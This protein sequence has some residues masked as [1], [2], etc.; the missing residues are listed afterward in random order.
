MTTPYLRALG[1]CIHDSPELFKA[2]PLPKVY[3]KALIRAAFPQSWR[4]MLAAGLPKKQLNEKQ[5]EL[6]EQLPTENIS[7]NEFVVLLNAVRAETKQT[8]EGLQLAGSNIHARNTSLPYLTKL[9]QDLEPAG[10]KISV[11]ADM[12]SIVL[13]AEHASAQSV[14]LSSKFYTENNTSFPTVAEYILPQRK[15]GQKEERLAELC[16]M[17]DLLKVD[18]SIIPGGNEWAAE[19]NKEVWNCK[20]QAPQRIDRV[21][22]EHQISAQTKQYSKLYGT[23]NMDALSRPLAT[24]FEDLNAEKLVFEEKFRKD[25]LTSM[26]KVE[27]QRLSTS[28]DSE[29]ALLEKHQLSDAEA[30][31]KTRQRASEIA[32]SRVQLVRNSVKA[33]VYAEPG[34]KEALEWANS[35]DFSRDPIDKVRTAVLTMEKH[36]NLLSRFQMQK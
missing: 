2:D 8:P 33:R 12:L 18:F 14:P 28:L 6:L 32:E 5:L 34:G 13:L 3:I 10:S 17:L 21:R 23:T 29:I 16:S 30:L 24:A 36:I 26:K 27:L 9:S 22:I 25:A 20:S 11:L 15:L 19:L 7:N 4:S 31:Q 1:E 35:N